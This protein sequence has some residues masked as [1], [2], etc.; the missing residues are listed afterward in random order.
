MGVGTLF[1][2]ILG[3]ETEYEYTEM[4]FINTHPTQEPDAWEAIIYAAHD[5]VDYGD[6]VVIKRD[7]AETFGGYVDTIVPIFSK[8]G[9]MVEVSGPCWKGLFAR[10]L[11]D[12]KMVMS[13][14]EDIVD[15]S[16]FQKCTPDEI[17]KFMVRTPQSDYVPTQA[18]IDAGAKERREGEG[19]NKYNDCGRSVNWV[20]T[21]FDPLAGGAG[22][23]TDR[24][25]DRDNSENFWS[26][27]NQGTGMYIKID[28][29]QNYNISGIRVECRGTATQV[30]VHEFMRNYKIETSHNNVDW[31]EVV[32]EVNH[33]VL[34]DVVHSWD[35]T[36]TT[37]GGAKRY[38]RITLTQDFET[39]WSI[40]EVYIYK[41]SNLPYYHHIPHTIGQGTVDSY[42]DYLGD[43][44]TDDV[45]AGINFDG[46]Y[47]VSEVFQMVAD[48]TLDAPDGEATVPDTVKLGIRAR[49]EGAGAPVEIKTYIW[50]G[51]AYQLV[52]T[53]STNDILG[54]YDDYETDITAILTT[55]AKVNDARLKV[56]CT[57]GGA[58]ETLRFRIKYAYL[59]VTIDSIV[60]I[61]PCNGKN[62]EL[63]QW[64][65]D[66]SWLEPWLSINGDDSD[67][68]YIEE[69]GDGVGD[70]SAG[71]LFQRLKGN[72]PWEWWIN[73]VK[74]RHL[75][76]N[77]GGYTNCVLT[78]IGKQVV[79]G[80]TG[81]TGTLLSYNN[82]LRY[83]WV[84][85]DDNADLFDQAE[86]VSVS[87]GTGTG[88]TS[89]ASTV[90]RT[91]NFSWRRGTD[92]SGS[93]EFKYDSTHAGGHFTG[94]VKKTCTIG[95]ILNRIRVIAGGDGLEQEQN[96][97]DWYEDATSVANYGIYEGTV[98]EPA[99]DNKGAAN[100]F[101]RAL[102]Y[103]YSK[104]R[105]MVK[106][107]VYDDN[108]TNTWGVGDDITLTDTHTGVSGK[109]RVMS[110]R[111]EYS[112]EGEVV[113]ISASDSSTYLPKFR[114]E[115]EPDLEFSHEGFRYIPYLLA[116]LT[117]W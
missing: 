75:T 82:T 16:F 10:R 89:G 60:Y 15:K 70:I 2:G 90:G 69:G 47:S 53:W 113:T 94:A 17:L 71:Y 101:A 117:S 79:G 80:T 114:P 35:P 58:A 12:Q 45:A 31:Y 116:K 41:A 65:V 102:V 64:D 38:V 85:M 77:A 7:G 46:N 87:G 103:E 43:Q 63:Q 100:A 24:I 54:T 34:R 51:A 73:C 9:T 95:S 26:N 67:D 1:I 97:S 84:E 68:Y 6:S 27:N 56:E 20:I 88:T 29:G 28:L 108:A 39:K 18:Q 111:R 11:M 78:D 109:Y 83:W 4:S 74:I 106:T 96:S 76:F 21:F 37:Q 44:E 42:G 33:N 48:L 66:P 57:A 104:L 50:N 92:K 93:I 72:R 98:D 23:S 22:G 19:I 25:W 5:D 91:W 110:V 61:L 8:S 3:A 105:N 52:A 99:I 115:L 55:I 107:R 49:K 81:D 36:D 14:S 59:E 86:V 30:R 62:S 32:P 40:T 112:D 13:G